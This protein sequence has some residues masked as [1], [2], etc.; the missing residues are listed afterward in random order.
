MTAMISDS[1]RITQGT[2]LAELLHRTDEPTVAVAY[3][4]LCGVM[5]AQG[6]FGEAWHW[7]GRAE[8]ALQ[9]TAEPGIGVGRT[10]HA[11]LVSEL[12]GLLAQ[13]GKQRATPGT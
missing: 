12:L 3:A 2:G 5:V 11:D 8:H 4:L 7:L 9:T 10:A 1:S 6:R 13:P